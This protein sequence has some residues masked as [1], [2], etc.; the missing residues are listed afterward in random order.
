MQIGRTGLY[1]NISIG[2][3]PCE[4]QLTESQELNC[5]NLDDVVSF[6]LHFVCGFAAFSSKVVTR[7]TRSSAG[8]VPCRWSSDSSINGIL[9]LVWARFVR[10]VQEGVR[11]RSETSSISIS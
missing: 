8:D 2:N 3:E 6:A 4:E 10:T 1:L 11:D 5:L 9:Q 7:V